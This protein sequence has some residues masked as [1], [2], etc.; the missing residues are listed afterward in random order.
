MRGG[1]AAAEAGQH[2]SG[3]DDGGDAN[4]AT[5]D[6]PLKLVEMTLRNTPYRWG[7]VSQ[8]LHW[9]IVALIITQVT[10]AQLAENSPPRS[11]QMLKW[12]ARHKSVGITI[13]GL[14]VIR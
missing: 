14:A 3:S 11:L 9:L 10:L 13:L 7:A 2:H 12:F 8:F 4:F 5:H 1:G 6:Y